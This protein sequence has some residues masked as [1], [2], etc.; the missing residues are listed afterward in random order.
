MLVGTP[1]VRSS[2]R[3]KLHIQMV[4][5]DVWHLA[6][7]WFGF[8]FILVSAFALL[9]D[10]KIPPFACWDPEIGIKAWV[11]KRLNQL[12]IIVSVRLV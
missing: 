8:C 7:A 1:G 10:P 2:L 11:S 9:I 4:K 6:S 3:V 5:E 12:D